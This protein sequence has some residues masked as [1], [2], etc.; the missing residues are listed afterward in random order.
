ME[1]TL[2]Y[3]KFLTDKAQETIKKH[4]DSRIAKQFWLNFHVTF[5]TFEFLYNLTI[6]CGW[7]VY[8]KT[9]AIGSQ[10]NLELLLLGALF[11]LGSDASWT[12]IGDCCGYTGGEAI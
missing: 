3:S 4:P 9:D 8:S 6:D 5:V 12:H 10:C 1:H 2:F 7:Y 11:K